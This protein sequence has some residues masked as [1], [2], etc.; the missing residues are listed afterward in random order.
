MQGKFFWGGGLF[1]PPFLGKKKFLEKCKV[2]TIQ[3]SFKNREIQGGIIPTGN[4]FGVE[5]FEG[6]D[7]SDGG[8][9]KAFTVL[10][11]YINFSAFYRD[12][13]N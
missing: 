4:F 10:M 11:I 5:N 6:E 12:N 2:A 8:A 1:R 7:Y 13:N 3:F 9:N